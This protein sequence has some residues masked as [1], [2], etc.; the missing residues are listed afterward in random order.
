MNMLVGSIVRVDSGNN[1]SR[2]KAI[3]DLYYVGT[4]VTTVRR[5]SLYSS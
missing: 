5:V 4:T 2:E 3:D 1:K